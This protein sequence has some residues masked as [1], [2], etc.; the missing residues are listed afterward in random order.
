MYTRLDQQYSN[1]IHTTDRL[2]NENKAYLLKVLG[3][4]AVMSMLQKYHTT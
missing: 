1:I 4:Y 2:N 3:F